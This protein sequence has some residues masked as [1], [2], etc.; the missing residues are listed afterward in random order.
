MTNKTEPPRTFSLEIAVEALN[1]RRFLLNCL[2]FHTGQ[3]IKTVVSSVDRKPT[4]YDDRQWIQIE[5]QDK[6]STL[7]ELTQNYYHRFTYQS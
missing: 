2:S 4:T 7:W 3:T 6:I 5:A 1:G